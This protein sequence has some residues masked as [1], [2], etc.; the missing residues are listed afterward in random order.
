[1][2]ASFA[3]TVVFTGYA[4][5]LAAPGVMPTQVGF[6]G[7][8]VL[9]LAWFASSLWLVWR[10]PSRIFSVIMSVVTTIAI[11]SWPMNAIVIGCYA[12]NDCP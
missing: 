9:A 1:M 6:A 2:R 8:I 3:L 7:Y 12:F 5:L 11:L 4:V 10:V